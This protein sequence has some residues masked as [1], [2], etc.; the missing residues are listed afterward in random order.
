MGDTYLRYHDQA[1]SVLRLRELC[2][3]DWMSWVVQ[4]A[5]KTGF[6]ND[7][8]G[9][10]V[11]SRAP[12]AVDVETRELRRPGARGSIASDLALALS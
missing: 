1:E 8:F 6:L 4:Y 9:L 5:Q 2:H 7:C 12:K 11:S 10:K 3:L